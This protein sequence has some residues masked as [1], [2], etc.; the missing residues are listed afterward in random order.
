MMQILS[1]LCALFKVLL[2]AT[3]WVGGLI[4]KIG[5]VVALVVGLIVYMVVKRTKN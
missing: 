2:S 1:A 4:L 3:V 5:L